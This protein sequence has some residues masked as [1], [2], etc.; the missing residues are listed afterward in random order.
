MLNTLKVDTSNL[1]ELVDRYLVM[2]LGSDR[3]DI[4]HKVDDAWGLNLDLYLKEL[5]ID[6]MED[7]VIEIEFPNIFSKIYIDSDSEVYENG[8]AYNF[9]FPENLN[10]FGKVH[11]LKD[12]GIALNTWAYDANKW[13]LKRNRNLRNVT[14]D[15]RKCK[16][17]TKILLFGFAGHEIHA[18]YL[19]DNVDLFGDSSFRD[20]KFDIIESHGVKHI[21]KDAFKSAEIKKLV[22]SDTLL[23]IGSGALYFKSVGLDSLCFCDTFGLSLYSIANIEKVYI[24]YGYKVMKMLTYELENIIN[25]LKTGSIT[26]LE[27]L[28]H[29]KECGI[30]IGNK[31]I[32]G[33]EFMNSIEENIYKYKMHK[34]DNLVHVLDG[35]ITS[36]KDAS[37]YFYNIDKDDNTATVRNREYNYYGS[38]INMDTNVELKIYIEF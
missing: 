17:I 22:L 11:F 10:Y 29:L 4:I 9:I 34:P 26:A 8:Q 28:A 16:C 23:S 3:K 6:Y 33:R 21:T 35:F 20:S 27:G 12:Y 32:C 24:P 13:Q 37:L 1:E 38:H 36:K 18:L 19:G 30:E 25:S 5:N 7:S 15:F 31:C 14:L 2:N